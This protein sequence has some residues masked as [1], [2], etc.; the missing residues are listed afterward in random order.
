MYERL[1]VDVLWAV[2]KPRL[3]A[4]DPSEELVIENVPPA[5]VGVDMVTA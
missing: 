1:I 4:V 2:P 3:Q 5:V